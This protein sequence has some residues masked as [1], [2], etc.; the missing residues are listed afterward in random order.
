MENMAAI[1][2]NGVVPGASD[3]AN[4]RINEAMEQKQ[5]EERILDYMEATQMLKIGMWSEVPS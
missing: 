2:K 4:E 1:M 5:A 3:A